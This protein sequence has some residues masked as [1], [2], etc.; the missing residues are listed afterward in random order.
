M[1]I[2]RLHPN[3]FDFILP[4]WKFSDSK[5]WQDGLTSSQFAAQNIS[6]AELSEEWE[7][8]PVYLHTE[9]KKLNQTANITVV[10]GNILIMDENA[11]K[12]LSR[13]ITP[14]GEWLPLHDNYWAFN[15]L[16]S[17]SGDVLDPNESVFNAD[18][19]HIPIKLK[20]EELKVSKPQLFKPGFVHNTF[21]L[22]N[23]R[24][25]STVEK[26]NLNGLLFSEDLT[27]MFPHKTD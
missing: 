19:T 20:I 4:M 11:K 6:L 26:A 17:V 12:A 24:L 22:C 14:L 3:H 27:N 15:C 5:L 16:N 10:N 21:L 23:E 9:S 25:K 7:P 18:E 1:T 13:L 2:Y 8:T